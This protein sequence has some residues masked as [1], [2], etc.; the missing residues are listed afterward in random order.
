M[1]QGYKKVVLVLACMITLGGLFSSLLLGSLAG[2]TKQ[3]GSSN[4]VR[5]RAS[6]TTISEANRRRLDA[7]MREHAALT[8]PLLKAQLMQDPDVEAITNIVEH[9]NVQIANTIEKIY[10]GT[11]DEFLPLWRQHIGYYND[12]LQATKEGDETG[13]QQAKQNLT[14]FADQASAVLDNANPRLNQNHIRQHLTSHGNRVT[15][16]IDNLVAENY[17]TVY[18]LAHNE[19][20]H[21]DN[22]ADAIIGR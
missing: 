5:N 3:G 7:P 1:K 8:V 2:A 9:N 19:Y 16:I 14:T 6:A 13:Q 20:E 12:Y 4:N 18:T 11:L 15:T 22:V 10:P 17:D 21:M